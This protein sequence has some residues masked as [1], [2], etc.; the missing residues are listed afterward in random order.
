ME[1]VKKNTR[2]SD[3]CSD[4]PFL[5]EVL[6]QTDDPRLTRG[7]RC[8]A[9]KRGELEAGLPA[10]S[11]AKQQN[12]KRSVR[13]VLQE[14]PKTSPRGEMQHLHSCAAKPRSTR[15]AVDTYTVL[16]WRDRMEAAK[17]RIDLVSLFSTDSSFVRHPSHRCCCCCCCCCLPRRSACRSTQVASTKPVEQGCAED[18]PTHPRQTSAIQLR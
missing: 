17:Y 6:V 2:Q 1:T 13:A 8:Y 3:P 15:R 12:G 7:L 5:E 10:A 18:I 11:A 9:E 14:M 4:W 16:L